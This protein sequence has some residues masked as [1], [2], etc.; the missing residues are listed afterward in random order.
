MDR[1]QVLFRLFGKYCP[2]GTILFTEGS[3]GQE[4]YFIQSGAVRVGAVRPATG[5]PGCLGPGD[6]LGEGS[7]FA[8]A[9]RSTRAE[10]VQDTRL[11]QV[12]DRTLD[13]VVRHGPQTAQ[14]IF[15][16]LLALTGSARSELSLWTILRLLGRIAPNLTAAAAGDIFPADLAERSGMP[17]ADVVLVL[18]E[19]RR[20]GCLSREGQRYRAADDALLRREIDRFATA[21]ER[22]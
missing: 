22:A 5:R 11:I 19:F 3:P 7:F 14:M 4:L 18:E 6:L 21:G 8:R 16:K 12:S 17:E 13:A 1:E 9:P 10:V 20:R 15:E 2:E